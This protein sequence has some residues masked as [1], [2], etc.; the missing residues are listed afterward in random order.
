M[1]TTYHLQKKL[2]NWQLILNQ[3]GIAQ[4]HVDISM[5]TN[6]SIS[7]GGMEPMNALFASPFTFI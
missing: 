6:Y 2:D 1:L 5:E 3:N 7:N 4:A